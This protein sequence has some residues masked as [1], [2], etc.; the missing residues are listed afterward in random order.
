MLTGVQS[1]TLDIANPSYSK[2]VAQQ[3]AEYNGTD[4]LAGPVMTLSWSTTA[5]MAT[6]P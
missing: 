2:Q 1:G 4:E 6:L 3:I 5:A